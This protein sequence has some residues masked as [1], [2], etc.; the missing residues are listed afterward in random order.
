MKEKIKNFNFMGIF[1][2]VFTA[3]LG[4][5]DASAVMAVG[6]GGEQITTGNGVHQQ[7]APLEVETKGQGMNTEEGKEATKTADDP[8]GIYSEEIDAF[9]TKIRPTVTPLDTILRHGKSKKATGWEFGWYSVDVLPVETKVATY[10]LDETPNAW[11]FKCATLTVDAPALF[12]ETDT[13]RI[14]GTDGSYIFYIQE[15]TKSGSTT[16]LLLSYGEEDAPAVSKITKGSVVYRLGRAAKE[17]DVQTINYAAY[18]VKDKNYCQIFKWQVAQSFIDSLHKK[19]VNWG[20]SDV[21]EQATYEFKL[22]QEASFLFGKK[23]RYIAKN[24]QEVYATGGI[25]RAI[26]DAGGILDLDTTAGNAGFIDLTKQIFQGNVG[27]RKRVV[28]MGSDFN[29]SISKIEAVQK[30]L[31][32]N[33]TKVIWGIE[34]NEIRTNFGS[35]MCMQHDLL[36]LYG[37]KDK[38]IVLDVDN[39]DKYV[40]FN[41]MKDLDMESTGQFDGKVK[42]YTE[43]AGVALRY[44]ATHAVVRLKNA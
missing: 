10:T 21:E 4:I 31:A 35:L 26:E 44:P 33:E 41:K 14:E 5:M 1:M 9:I 18:P 7:G 2:L 23:T 43:V 3:V 27:N 20:M 19:D 40:W 13:I 17:G 28:F 15:K 25:V 32:S 24:D 22:A 16:N 39:I 42:V 34:W 8:N 36:D 12:Q 30:Q 38:A 29:A 37:Y 6:F 11:G